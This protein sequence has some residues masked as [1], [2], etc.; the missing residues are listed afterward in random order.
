MVISISDLPTSNDLLGI[1]KY[2]KGLKSFIETCS[3]P[4][5][6]SIQGDWGIGKTSMM[7]Q[8]QEKL[9]NNCKTIWFNTWQ[10]SQFNL[11]PYLSVQFLSALIK[12]IESKGETKEQYN[13]VKKLRKTIS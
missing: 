10:F 12:E 11:T 1:D 3:T 6:I 5:S 7:R 13:R 9:N 4:L 8:V 2:T